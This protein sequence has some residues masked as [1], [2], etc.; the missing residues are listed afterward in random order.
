LWKSQK[1]HVKLTNV[2]NESI[3]TEEKHTAMPF[4]DF[5]SQVVHTGSSARQAVFEAGFLD[6]LLY[7][8]M[9]DFL[10]PL[11]SY[12]RYME[13]KHQTPPLIRVCN[14]ILLY[15]GDD[16][17]SLAVIRG[18]PLHILWPRSE[19]FT[20]KTGSQS[21]MLQQRRRT[22]RMLEKQLID[23]RFNVIYHVLSS[24]SD[25]DLLDACVDFL[26]FMR[27]VCSN[28]P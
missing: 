1:D 14:S 9:S 17:E 2:Y 28:S 25:S 26:E 11:R 7:M 23:M 10:D 18:H 24:D 15:L 8:Y 21:E 5:I 16:N 22:W 27:W 12:G 20:F 19:D 4:I 3:S 13:R 6:L